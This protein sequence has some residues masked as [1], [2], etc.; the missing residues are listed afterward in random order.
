[1]DPERRQLLIGGE[2]EEASGGGR[3]AKR[4]PFTGR[5]VTEAAA[6]GAQDARRAVDAAQ[7]ALWTWA[8]TPPAERRARLTR[9]AELLMERA[10]QIAGVMTEE[11]GATFGWGMFN[12]DLASRM[13]REAAAQA[14]ALVGDVIPSDVPGALSFG[15][16]QPAGVVVGMAPWNA[17][18]PTSTPR[19]TPPA[20]AR[21]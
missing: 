19:P 10:P 5:P 3:F 18:T 13:L 21:S 11:V 15:V 7:A 12:C 17:P 16:R 6:A 14:Y 2:W 1:M 4:D 8:D 9:A 20:S